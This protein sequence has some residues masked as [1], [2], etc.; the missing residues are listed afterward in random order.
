MKQNIDQNNFIFIAKPWILNIYSIIMDI[1]SQKFSSNSKAK[2]KI[3]KVRIKK[4]FSYKDRI[5]HFYLYKLR[6]I[7][8]YLDMYSK[9]K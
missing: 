5:C 4:S 7:R 3:L 1:E 8:H 6:L 2:L 9:I